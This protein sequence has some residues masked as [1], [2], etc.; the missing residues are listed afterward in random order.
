M[1]AK[2]AELKEALCTKS[3]SLSYSES[4]QQS[5]D[6]VHS[7][8]PDLLGHTEQFRREK[9]KLRKRVERAKTSR[10][11]AVCK[12]VRNL[13]LN[14]AKTYIIKEKGVITPRTCTLIRS[15]MHC[16]VP[17]G[18][19][20]NA[21]ERVLQTAGIRVVGRFDRHSVRRIVGEGAVHAEV[22]IAHELECSS[23]KLRCTV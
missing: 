1:K 16:G 10:S 3:I 6:P 21:I 5:V 4:H 11:M 13:Q 22:Q 15:L 20:Y 23:S 17:M 12:A 9:D 18:N 7:L 19:I 8:K 14:A 2:V